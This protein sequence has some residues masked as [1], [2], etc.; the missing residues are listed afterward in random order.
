MSIF[1]KAP[2]EIE[3]RL[4]SEQ[5][6]P[7]HDAKTVHGRLESLPI[8]RDGESVVGS[9]I[10][11]TK[12]GRHVDHMGIKVQ[13]LGSIETNIDGVLSSEFLSLATELAAPSTISKSE[14]FAFEFQNVQKQYESYRGKSA[15]LRYY[16]KVT[17]SRKSAQEMKREK[18]LWVF[19]PVPKLDICHA[20][21]DRVKIDVG[22]EQC[23]HIEFDYQKSHYSLNDVIIGK[24]YFL[25]VRI[26]IKHMEVSLIRRE[27]V[28]QQ[29]HQVTES[30][31]MVRFEIMDGSPVKG[32]VIPIRLF[33]AGFD[34][35]P[36]YIDVNKK[37][38][39]RTFL[40]LVLIDE[41]ARRYF[42]Q[43]E[44]VLCRIE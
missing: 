6:R 29:P 24:I 26:K 8:Y 4:E 43:S 3:I 31:T 35:V 21:D 22:I 10:V 9:V 39:V 32:E 34:L 30:K 37:F 36:T 2:L 15:T 20:P 13:L 27:T 18:E 33:L 23:L 38:S 16:I 44:I 42:K 17:V 12:D 14:T 11:R 19:R 1:F 5:K 40:S 7:H 25:L 41:D 28:G